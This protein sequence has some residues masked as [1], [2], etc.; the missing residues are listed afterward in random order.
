MAVKKKENRGG[1]RKGA[2]QPKGNKKN[3]NV[4]ETTKGK[5]LSAAEK[6]AE[7]Y[8]KP[9]EEA[10]LELVY[11]PKTQDSVKASIFKTY[12]E[13]LVAKESEQNINVNKVGPRIGLPPMEEDPALKLVAKDGKTVKKEANG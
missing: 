1:A 13:A 9:I 3:K 11:K 7:E 5:I 2:G 4:S 6:L 12:L 10:M 8:G